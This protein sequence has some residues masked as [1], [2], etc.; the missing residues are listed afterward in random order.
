[1]A[2]GYAKRLIKPTHR[3]ITIVPTGG[4]SVNG[5]RYM[6][7]RQSTCGATQAGGRRAL[8]RAGRLGQQRRDR[9][10]PRTAPTQGQAS[11]SEVAMMKDRGFVYVYGTPS[12]RYGAV[13]LA[14]VPEKKIERSRRVRILVGDPLGEERTVG[15]DADHDAPTGELSVAYTGIWAATSP[16]PRATARRCARPRTRGAM[17]RR[18]NIVPGNDRSAAT[19]RSSTRGRWT[20]RRCSSRIR[21]GTVTRSI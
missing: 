10:S 3:G 12:G 8:R 20:A 13:Y 5:K 15:R 9:A 21:S 6:G 18:H 4:I 19:H 16:S 14:R 17:D 7:I 11:S 1:M 2:L